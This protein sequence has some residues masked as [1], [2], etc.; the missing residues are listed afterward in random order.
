MHAHGRGIGEMWDHVNVRVQSS[1]YSH[2]SVSMLTET[3]NVTYFTE[4]LVRRL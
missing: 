1:V 3:G 2:E 4:M